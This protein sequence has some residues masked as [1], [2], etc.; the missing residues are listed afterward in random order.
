MK[1]IKVLLFANSDWYLYN[2]RR[3]LAYALVE[4]GHDVVLVS[5]AGKYG[6]RLQELGFRWVAAPMVRSSLNPLRELRLL[7]WLRRLIR[8]EQVE[9]VHG[10]T[11]KAAVYGALASRLAGRC[12]SVSS[13][14]GLGYVFIN[15]GLKA[16]ILQAVLRV[17]FDL[18]FGGKACEV[19][20][21]NETDGEFFT[22]R[23][24]VARRQLSVI[25][26][27]GIDCLHYAPRV[28]AGASHLES[29]TQS[30]QSGARG[31]EPGGPSTGPRADSTEPGTSSSRP[32]NTE[33]GRN[34]PPRILVASR[35]L[36]D[37][38]LAEFVEAAEILRGRGCEAEFLIAGSADSGNPATVADADIERWAQTGTVQLLGHVD[39]MRSLLHTVD[40]AVLPSYREGLPK[41]LLEAAACGL[42]A[43][44]T[45][46]PGCRDVVDH[47]V[48]GYLVPPRQVEALANAI[49]RML[50]N[51]A[52]MRR[53]GENAR[54]RAE[55]EFDARIITRRTIAT[56]GRVL[57]ALESA[58]IVALPNRAFSAQTP[59]AARGDDARTKEDRAA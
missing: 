45:D 42:P 41:S 29:G 55:Q 5:P 4:Q 25:P 48:S 31:T 57:A 7:L 34:R 54:R 40:L 20:V 43:V 51:P 58:D 59:L 50:Q 24:L 39:D 49:E 27:S 15:S 46:V 37:K 6:D 9:V 53:M 22:S 35:L 56:Y 1:P 13:I 23:K 52:E 38:G 2:F 33:T 17:L 44:T 19:I 30:T 32:G 3:N 18:S 36:W 10:F 16:R 26:G 8:D 28:E 12:G 21:Q 47:D 11:I 14:A